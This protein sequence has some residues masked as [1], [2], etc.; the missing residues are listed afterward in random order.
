MLQIL[1]NDAFINIR[2]ISAF[3]IIN[4]QNVSVLVYCSRGNSFLD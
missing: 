3:K 1:Y 4:E 2:V